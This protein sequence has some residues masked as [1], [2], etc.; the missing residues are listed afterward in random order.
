MSWKNNPN[1]LKTLIVYAP[2]LI[3][4]FFTPNMATAVV[5]L[6]T[7]YTLAI[8]TLCFFIIISLV[9]LLLGKLFVNND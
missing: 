3:L 1:W 5:G 6:G 7:P 2:L 9:A 8:T 4:L